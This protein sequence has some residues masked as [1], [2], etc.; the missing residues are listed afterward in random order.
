MLHHLRKPEAVL[1]PSAPHPRGCSAG[2]CGRVFGVKV[3]PAPAGML[4]RWPRDT[5]PHP[6][7]PRT[8][9]D[10]PVSDINSRRARLSAPHP[11]GCSG[12]GGAAVAGGGVGPAPAGMLLFNYLRRAPHDRRP[13]TRGDAPAFRTS[14][15]TSTKSAPH[16]RGCSRVI[17]TPRQVLLVGPAPA[18]MLPSWTPAA[19]AGP[20]RPRTRGDAPLQRAGVRVYQASAP[21]PRGCSP[22][23]RCPEI[24]PRVGPAPAGM[25]R[26]ATVAPAACVRRPRTR[27]D[28][29][30][31][32]RQATAPGESAPHPRGCSFVTCRFRTPDEVGP[33]PAGMLRAAR[34]STTTSSPSA[35]HPRGCSVL[36][37]PAKGPAIVGP[38]P[39]GM[40][41]RTSTSFDATPGRPRTRGD[42][43]RASLSSSLRT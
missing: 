3:G 6:G 18:G 35:P 34:P 43:P 38:A 24:N 12:A 9:G 26:A 39:A 25:L 22:P 21:D 30:L 1:T 40:L 33:A 36:V 13:R 31:T 41:R 5:H 7:R 11:R 37:T 27:G 29:P 23:S 16:P 19:P 15:M 8:R 14:R 20:S 2:S 10:A 28:A 32:V 17:A 42:A 4:R